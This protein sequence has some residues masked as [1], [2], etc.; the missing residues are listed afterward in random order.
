MAQLLFLSP[1]VNMKKPAIF[2]DRDGTLIHDRKLIKNKSDVRLLPGASASIKKFHDLGFDV[3]VITN[4]GAVARGYITEEDV[5]FV[6][7]II[8]SRLKK[9]STFINSFYYCP[10]HPTEAKIKKFSVVC[11]CRKPEIGQVLKAAKENGLD[12]HNSYFVGD[13]TSDILTGLNAKMKTIL[14]KTGHS[15]QDNRYEVTPDFVVKNLSD[16]VSLI[17]KILEK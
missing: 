8:Q 4:Q 7:C 17:K 5:K 14:V 11:E 13:M 1:V 9:K 12:L 15:G 6:H 3:F 2:L 16:A 10:H